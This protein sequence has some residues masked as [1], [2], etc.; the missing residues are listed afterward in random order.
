MPEI[1]ISDS[2]GRDA[3]V[4]MAGVRSPLKVRWVDSQGRQ[5]TGAKLLKGT[6]PTDIEA[7]KNQNKGDLAEIGKALIAGD[8]EI[9]FENTGRFLKDTSRVYVDQNR[10]IVHKV[11]FFDIVRNPDGTLLATGSGD[12]SLRLW[13]IPA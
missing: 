4:A 8:P 1:N 10:Q 7:L 3:L 6:L 11:K 9:D 2:R 5:S 13:G 12:N